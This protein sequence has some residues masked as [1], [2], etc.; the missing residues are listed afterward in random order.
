MYP[1]NPR[2][3]SSS[4]S[5]NCRNAT[6]SRS[7]RNS[8]KPCW[9]V[10]ANEAPRGN[11]QLDEVSKRAS[12]IHR[13]ITASVTRVGQRG[14]IAPI[15]FDP[16]AALAI[17]GRECRL[18]HDYLVAERLEVLRDQLALG[19]RLQQNPHR[20]PPLEHGG[21]AIACRRDPSIAHLI[22]TLR[23]NRT[24]LSF[25]CRSM[26]PYSM[27]GLLLCHERVSVMWSARYHATQQTSRFILS[28]D[29]FKGRA[30]EHISS[31]PRWTEKSEWQIS[32]SPEAQFSA[33]DPVESGAGQRRDIV[34][35]HE[36]CRRS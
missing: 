19:G 36:F 24:W 4:R 2:P 1:V 15:G 12:L 8:D 29:G 18:G 35:H 22:T 10:I 13:A 16:S 6:R 9:L 34:G 32:A 25:L 28:T 20:A 30:R 14:D 26:A 5:N 21:E 23:D 7:R 33:A 17:H 31:G 3:L 27:A 11:G